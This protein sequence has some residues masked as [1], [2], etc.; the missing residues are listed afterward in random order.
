MTVSDG[1]SY[2]EDEGEGY[3]LIQSHYLSLSDVSNFDDLIKLLEELRKEY[4]N[5]TL[6]YITYTEEDK[7]L[8]FSTRHEVD[9]ETLKKHIE[10]EKEDKLACDLWAKFCNMTLEERVELAKHLGVT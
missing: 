10:K 7:G 9:E 2:I 1:T 6:D 5:N 3:K 4:G 8:Q